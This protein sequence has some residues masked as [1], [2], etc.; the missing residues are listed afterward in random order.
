MFIV[1]RRK[2]G[3][4]FFCA[5]MT[6]KIFIIFPGYNLVETKQARLVLKNKGRKVDSVLRRR[7]VLLN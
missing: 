4:I 3:T 2:R 5:F 7:V 1:P 6:D